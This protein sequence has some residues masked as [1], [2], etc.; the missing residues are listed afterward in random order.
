MGEVPFTPNYEEVTP[1]GIDVEME[2]GIIPETGNM[3]EEL[4]AWQAMAQL[5]D[6]DLQATNP[7]STP[8]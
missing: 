8:Y 6:P 1:I 2:L 5:A 4:D 7:F 3:I